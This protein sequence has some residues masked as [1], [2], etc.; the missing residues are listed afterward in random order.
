[1]VSVKVNQ[2]LASPQVAF[3]HCFLTTN[4]SNLGQLTLEVAYYTLLDGDATINLEILYCW[5]DVLFILFSI[6]M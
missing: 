4:K 1:M 2:T 5:T 6:I 3:I